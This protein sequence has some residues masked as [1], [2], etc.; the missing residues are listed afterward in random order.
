[1]NPGGKKK[2]HQYSEEALQKSV[3]SVKAGGNLRS[4]CRKYGVPKSTVQDRISGKVA[5]T[6]TQ[7]GPDPILS[8][9]YENKLVQWIEN[10]AKCG[11]PLKK[12]ELLD[13]IPKI[14]RAEKL[15]TPFKND[16][17]CFYV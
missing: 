6:N 2:F 10:L 17:S 5:K 16:S 4:V 11:F 12:G 9:E 1:M 3:E 14:V 7:M 15:Q 13:T 8:H